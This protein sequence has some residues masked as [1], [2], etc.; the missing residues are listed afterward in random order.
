MKFTGKL[1]KFPGKSLELPDKDTEFPGKLQELPGK[2]TNFT[3]NHQYHYYITGLDPSIIT[4]FIV[5]TKT[6]RRGETKCQ[7]HH[8]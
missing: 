6:K 1:T 8:L 3:G 4:S 7:I 2:Y 5:S